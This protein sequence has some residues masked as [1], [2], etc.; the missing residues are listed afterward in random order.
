MHLIKKKLNRF[1]LPFLFLL[2]LL[3]STVAWGKV[4]LDIDAPAFQQFA[5]AVPD[6]QP[7]AGI[8]QGQDVIAVSA[9]DTL[10][11]LLRI[12]G[13]FNVIN[14]KAYLDDQKSVPGDAIDAIRFSDWMV[15][16]AEYLVK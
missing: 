5:I 1:I 10:A 15:I 3:C 12:T 7:S 4:Y 14:K 2:P 9:A 16:G 6:F 13:Y 8:A 11:N